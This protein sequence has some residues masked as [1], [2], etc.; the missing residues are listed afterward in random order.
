MKRSLA[1]YLKSAVCTAWFRAHGI[2]S[3][4]VACDGRLPVL[5]SKGKVEIGERFITRG[6]IA[7]CEI[8]ATVPDARLK[9]GD[10]VFINQGASVTAT[11]YVEIGD[12]TQIGPFTTIYDTNYHTVD[13][14]HP[15]QSAPV[16]IG[17]NVWLGHG[18][19][20]LPGSKI[21]DHTVVAAG[22]VVKGDLPPRVL[23]AGN[24]AQVVRELHIPEGWRRG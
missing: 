22:S 24:P 19:V 11:C 15:L 3:S 20:V 17:T 9:I 1:F 6:R 5:Y 8:G 10:R 2:R 21:G 7:R 4:L 12:D 18:V 23:A 13:P 16:I 14:D